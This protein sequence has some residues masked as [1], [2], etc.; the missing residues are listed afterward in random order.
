[1]TEPL[2]VELVRHPEVLEKMVASTECAVAVVLVA[3]L[4]FE[5]F[6]LVMP[7]NMTVQ[8]IKA[9]EVN[10]TEAFECLVVLLLGVFVELCA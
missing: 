8:G 7:L 9:G 10:T 2:L 1:M 4:T 3:K 6:G 5:L